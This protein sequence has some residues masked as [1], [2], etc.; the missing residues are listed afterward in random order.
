MVLRMLMIASC[1]YGHYTVA[2]AMT[3]RGKMEMVKLG[4]HHSALL[5]GL[6]N[7]LLLFSPHSS[8]SSNLAMSLTWAVLWTSMIGSAIGLNWSFELYPGGSP[9]GLLMVRPSSNASW[10]TVCSEL[11]SDNAALRAC[12]SLGYNVTAAHFLANYDPDVMGGPIYLND[13]VCDPDTYFLPQCSFAFNNGSMLP[14]TECDHSTDVGV[15]CNTPPVTVPSQWEFRLSGYNSTIAG[16]LDFRPN[17]TMSWGSVCG[18]GFGEQAA[19]AACHSLGFNVSF[20][21]VLTTVPIGSGPVYLDH[22]NCSANDLFLQNCSFIYSLPENI[23]SSCSH[24]FDIGVNC[25][26][27]LPQSDSE[28]VVFNVSTP[29]VEIMVNNLCSTFGIPTSRVWLL[30]VQPGVLPAFTNVS[31]RFTDPVNWMWFSEPPRSQLDQF[32]LFITPPSLIYMFEMYNLTSNATMNDRPP[33]LQFRIANGS[34]QGLLE[35]RPSPSEPWGT[36]CSDDFDDVDAMAACHSVGFS[37]T[38]NA[39]ALYNV[40]GGSGTIYLDYIQCSAG[41]VFVQNC[42]YVYSTPEAMYNDCTHQN[43]VGIACGLETTPSPTTTTTTAAPTTTTTT[44]TPAPTT[45][46]AAPTTTTTTAAPT[47]TTTAAAPTTTTTEAPTTTTTTAVPTT[48]T[49]S[50]APTTM[51]M[52]PQRTT[53]PAPPAAVASSSKMPWYLTFAI[54]SALAIAAVVLYQK[55]RQRNE[56]GSFLS[57]DGGLNLVEY[58]SGHELQL[59][60]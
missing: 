15:N 53:T 40:P 3:S 9:M 43:D 16:R 36:V 5:D 23:W 56:T 32:L 35:V 21:Y 59:T 39:T 41:D 33:Q 1:F 52:T 29:S 17:S 20:A 37:N 45:T 55:F 27:V 26:D 8:R 19:I 54:G 13:V 47:T 58:E 4:S 57:S 49:T 10:G 22:V 11:F 30:R 28:I 6:H 48:T 50:A 51:T 31:F 18:T 25:S 14:W 7:E 12:H 38:T 24:N 46:T 42:T 44:A 34:T 60:H 2:H